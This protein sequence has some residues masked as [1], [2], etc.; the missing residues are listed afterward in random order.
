[1]VQ[2]V[3]PL[4]N[5]SPLTFGHHS[6]THICVDPTQ[7]S[8]SFQVLFLSLR[9]YSYSTWGGRG[10]V[11]VLVCVCVCVLVCVCVGG[12]GCTILYAVTDV[13]SSS[14]PPRFC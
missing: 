1:M 10:G 11:C 4:H 3:R 7:H 14:G 6:Y 2:P 5:H 8:S 9:E 12:G 13:G